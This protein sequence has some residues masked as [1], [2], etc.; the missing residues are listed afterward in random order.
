MRSWTCVTVMWHRVITHIHIIAYPLFSIPYVLGM[1]WKPSRMENVSR[2]ND[3][4]SCR[5]EEVDGFVMCLMQVQYPMMQ[6][7]EIVWKQTGQS[8]LIFTVYQQFYSCFRFRYSF[9]A[10]IHVIKFPLN[11]LNLTQHQIHWMCICSVVAK[12]IHCYMLFFTFFCS[13][14]CNKCSFIT[15]W[16][17]RWHK[18]VRVWEKRWEQSSPFVSYN[19]E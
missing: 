10:C 18:C 9:T 16:S 4:G 19:R 2:K 17:N 8:I 14:S 12:H 11:T 13:V 6:C 1:S 5:I 7:I 15:L 3:C